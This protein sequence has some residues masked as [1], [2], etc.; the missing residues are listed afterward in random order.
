MIA[1]EELDEV[2]GIY[3]GV[4]SMHLY[5]IWLEEA[6]ALKTSKYIA[7]GLPVIA[8][9]MIRFLRMNHRIGCGFRM[10]RNY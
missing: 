2:F 4:A 5:N 3:I 1:C 7:K 6:Y 8:W 10:M 9:G